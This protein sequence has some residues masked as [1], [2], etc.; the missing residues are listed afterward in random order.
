MKPVAFY[1]YRCIITWLEIPVR[2]CLFP[3][4]G[5]FRNCQATL[6]WFSW[7]ETLIQKMML[8]ETQI[9]C[10]QAFAARCCLWVPFFGS[11]ATEI[12]TL[13]YR[14]LCVWR[15]WH[16][17]WYP[18]WGQRDA[19]C[20]LVRWTL[21]VCGEGCLWVLYLQFWGSWQAFRPFEV[22][23]GTN[24]YSFILQFWSSFRCTRWSLPN[25]WPC[26]GETWGRPSCCW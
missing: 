12:L 21:V 7:E 26:R 13:A 24:F 9:F 5:P 23:R 3:N 15:E 11:E 19:P 22:G 8:S 1:L 25:C 10:P 16:C 6:S 2:T 4:Y 17:L 18:G 14:R 20:F